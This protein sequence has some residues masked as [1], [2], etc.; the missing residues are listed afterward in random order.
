MDFEPAAAAVELVEESD[1][2]RGTR[3]LVGH[4][5]VAVGVVIQQGSCFLRF[6]KLLN[7]LICGLSDSFP[8]PFYVVE[9]PPSIPSNLVEYSASLKTRAITVC[10][11]S[12]KLFHAPLSLTF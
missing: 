8:G 10:D 1:C 9:L 11:T 5:A 2:G 3:A 4:V 12:I 7:G 6:D